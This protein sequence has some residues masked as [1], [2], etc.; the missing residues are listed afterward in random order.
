MYVAFYIFY[1]LDYLVCILLSYIS[2]KFYAKKQI[3]KFKFILCMMFLFGNYLLIFTLPY[4]IIYYHI[5]KDDDDDE[6]EKKD[7][8]ELLSNNYKI[9][10][11]ILTF[12]SFQI[13]PYVINYYRSGEFTFWRRV[14][15]GI[16]STIKFMV[17][18]IG[19][20]S[21]LVGI[22][23]QSFGQAFTMIFQSINIIQA[24]IFLGLSIVNLPRKMHILS[25][26]NVALKYY[27]YKIRKIQDDLNKNNE[28][29]IKFYFKCKETFKYMEN[30]EKYLQSQKVSNENDMINLID[31]IEIDKKI[32]NENNAIDK[33]NNNDKINDNIKN[34]ENKEDKE[35]KENEINKNLENKENIENEED[36]NI[37]DIEK[38]KKEINK[39]YQKHKKILEYKKYINE[40]Y[41]IICK[42]LKQYNIEILEEQEEKPFKEYKKIVEAHSESKIID[43]DNDR[44]NCQM[45]KI[46]KHW[47]FLKEVSLEENIQL[48]P[49]LNNN[50]KN[51]SLITKTNEDNFIPTGKISKEKFVFIKNIINAYIFF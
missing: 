40:F 17:I 34:D 19:V 42:M 2:V 43:I 44:I 45:Q 22:L 31:E 23:G 7:I 13:I 28:K 5:E 14:Y 12:L 15:D 49:I 37:K 48:I 16:K 38:E 46:Y 18:F 6:D 35:N 26:I 29:L 21:I 8:K 47:S 3:S 33:E 32:E 20:I 27:E 10:F 9:I 36:K 30:I 39:D 50:I 51:D 24:F 1:F 25:N 4:E 41:S 11:Y